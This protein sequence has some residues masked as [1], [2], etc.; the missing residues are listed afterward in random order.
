[1]TLLVGSFDPH[2]RV[3]DMTYNVFGETLNRTQRLTD[4]Q[5]DRKAIAGARRLSSY[6]RANYRYAPQL[7]SNQMCI[8]QLYRRP[9]TF[10]GG[11]HSA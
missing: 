8:Q 4:R 7:Q 2:K 5:T 9:Q 10:S 3:P 1:L 6:M 11:T